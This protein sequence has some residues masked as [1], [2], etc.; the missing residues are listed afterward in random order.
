MNQAEKVAHWT[1]GYNLWKALLAGQTDAQIFDDSPCLGFWRKPIIERNE[2]GNNRRVGWKPVAIYMHNGTMVGRVG[3]GEHLDGES[4]VEIWSFIA[5]YPIPEAWYRDVAEGR[6]PWPDAKS[7][8]PAADRDVT[9]AD[10]DPPA[11]LTDADHAAGIDAAIGAALKVVTNEAEAAQALGSKNRIAELRLAADKAGR[12]LYDP[13]YREYK[14]LHGLWSPMVTRADTKEKAINK[15]ILTFRESERVRI[16]NEAAIAA[17]KQREIDEANQRIVDRAIERNEP[18][19]IESFDTT[20]IVAPAP[21]SEIV[22]TYG[23]RKIKEELHTILDSI[24]DYDA[25]YAFLKAEP[26]VKAL[27][28][29]LATAKVKAGFTVPGTVTHE[30]YV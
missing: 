16:A 17:A 12:S 15:A 20:E 7:E 30:G 4:L 1:Q 23:T 24:T 26:K 3:S 6:Q 11:V 18:L 14:R 21:I 2:R 9:N 28:L 5:K 29:E 25:V 27:L 22:P 8:I 19:T 13:P 10:N